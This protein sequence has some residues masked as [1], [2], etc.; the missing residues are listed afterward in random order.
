MRRISLALVVT[1]AIVLMADNVNAQTQPEFRLGF[2]AL[3]EQIPEVVGQPLEGE[4]WGSNGDSLQKTSKG[5]MVW[6]KADNWTAF[7]NGS[8]TWINGPVGVQERA[9]SDRF[10]WEKEIPTPSAQPAPIPEPSANPAPTAPLNRV[11]YDGTAVTINSVE[12][13]GQISFT[14][15]PRPGNTHLVVDLTI[16]NVGRT[17]VHYGRLW[18][19]VKASDNYEY[20]TSLDGALLQGHLQSGD[21]SRGE[22][23]RGKLAF[24]IPINS[25]G[26]TLVYEYDG[27]LTEKPMRISLQ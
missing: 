9:N 20:D 27:I 13:I 22:K 10:D 8:R 6:R 5:L 18:F 23:A 15:T 11:V 24:E 7:T 2:K 1:V 25:T 14:G 3:A 17:R 21:L 12:R 19:N 26:F 16:E 4:H